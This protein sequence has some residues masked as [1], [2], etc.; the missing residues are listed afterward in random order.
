MFDKFI[1]ND[2]AKNMVRIGILSS[3]KKHDKLPN[4]M[5]SGMAGSGK[6]TLAKMAAEEANALCIYINAST[7][8][9]PDNIIKTIEKGFERYNKDDMYDRIMIIIDEAHALKKKVEDFLLTAISEDEICVNERGNITSYKIQNNTTG[10]NDFLSWVFVSNRCGELA[11]ALR[12]RLTEVQ[13][14]TYKESDKEEIADN[15]VESL[16]MEIKEDAQAAISKRSWSIRDVKQYVNEVYDYA[17]VNDKKIITKELVEEYFNMVGIDENGL[18]ALEHEYLKIVA[19]TGNRASV[20]T[21]A[22]KL[23]VGTKDVTEIIE[24]RLLDLGIIG[25]DSGGRYV[26]D[27]SNMNPFVGRKGV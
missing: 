23:S 6:T 26:K 25:I 12:S 18:G 2:M 20:Q 9:K 3:I 17:I 19:D 5:F 22:S 21:I 8:D 24:P 1:G 27:T 16:G 11:Q 14:V 4:W 15:Y 10:K 13:F 7:V